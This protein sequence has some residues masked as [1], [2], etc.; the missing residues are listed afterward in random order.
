MVSRAAYLLF[1]LDETLYPSSCGLMQEVSRR[2]TAFVAGYLK[3]DPQ[4]AAELRKELSR[5]YGTTLTG[6]IREHGLADPES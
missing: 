5:K 4:R 6:L 1:D 2:M 3:I